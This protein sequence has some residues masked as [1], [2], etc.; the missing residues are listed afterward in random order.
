MPWKK[1][2]VK[3]FFENFWKF[4]KFKQRQPSEGHLC[5]DLKD[6]QKFS[7]KKL[8]RIFLG[9]FKKN[10]FEPYRNLTTLVKNFQKLK[11]KCGGLKHIFFGFLLLYPGKVTLMLKE[12]TYQKIF[13]RLTCLSLPPYPQLYGIVT[14][15]RFRDSSSPVIN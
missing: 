3:I 10:F 15:K 13:T 14:P 12:F 2:C 1:F 5:L 11:V 4:S 9:H 7:K 8:Y 6:F